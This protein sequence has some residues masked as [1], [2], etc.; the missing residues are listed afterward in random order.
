METLL[1]GQVQ[2]GVPRDLV[3]QNLLNNLDWMKVFSAL[4]IPAARRSAN[5]LSRRLELSL[6]EVT[7][8]LESLVSIG[9]VENTPHGF[10][11]LKNSITEMISND[12][13]T[14]LLFA[15]AVLGELA[16]LKKPA[17][18]TRAVIPSTAEQMAK[19]REKIIEA[20]D[21][22]VIDSQQTEPEGLYCVS[23]N[24]IQS[25]FPKGGENV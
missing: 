20:F 25:D 9:L 18:Y 17:V 12:R 4:E 16:D 7:R 13:D 19:F 14:Y 21:Q 5:S 11:K 1:P 6:D 10:R 2:D 24:A 15:S 8:I 3:M 23:F 22:L